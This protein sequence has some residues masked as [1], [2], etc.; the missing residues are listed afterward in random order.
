MAIVAG[1]TIF[2]YISYQDGFDAYLDEL[3]WNGRNTSW[4]VTKT[5]YDKFVEVLK[6]GKFNSKVYL[7]IG[8]FFLNHYEGHI[9]AETKYKW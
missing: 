8:V 6:E 7:A 2:G 9:Q 3:R 5:Q 1:S 4:D